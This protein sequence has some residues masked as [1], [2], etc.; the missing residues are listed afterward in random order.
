MVLLSNTWYNRDCVD[1]P[2]TVLENKQ[3]VLNELRSHE[4]SLQWQLN[5]VQEIIRLAGESTGFQVIA[6]TE[7]EDFDDDE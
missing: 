5:N 2:P 3:D 6:E 7:D 1:S 4:K